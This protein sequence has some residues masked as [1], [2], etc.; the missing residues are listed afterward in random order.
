MSRTGHLQSSFGGETNGDND[1]TLLA[2]LGYKQELKR[3][4]TIVE[5]FGFGFSVNAVVPSIAATLFYSMPNG[6]P[7]AMIWGWATSS[8]F[9][10]FIALAMAELGS[11]APTS[12][13]IYYWTYK[14]CSP[15][16]R[17]LMCWM[18]GYTNTIS[19]IAG[20]AGL[21]WTCATVI[22]A[23]ASIGSDGRFVP[24]QHQTLQVSPCPCFLAHMFS[25]SGVFCAVLISQASIA[26]CAT[27]VIARLQNALIVL[28]I[29]LVLI[30]IIGL[31]IA[32]PAEF[33][34]TAKYA[35]GAFENATPWPN[36]FTF[37]LGFLAPLW[38]IS[39]FDVGVH[40]S[41]E[42]KNANVAVPWAIVIGTLAGCILGFPVQIALAFYMGTDIDAILSSPVQQPLG[43]IILN[44]F[45][46]KGM[47]VVW[48]FLLVALYGAATS[49]LTSSS[50]QTFAFSRDG[51]LVFSKILYKINSFTGTPVRCVWFSATIA[52]A[53]T[54]LTFAGPAATGAIFSLG[55]IGQYIGN[56]V[57]IAARYLGGQQFEKG[58]FYLGRFSKPV[59]GIALLWM[60]FMTL[61]L[62]FPTAPNPNA[63]DW[64][65]T[66]VVLAGVFSIALGYYYFPVFGGRHWFGGPVST[67]ETENEEK[68]SS[69]DKLDDVPN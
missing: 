42:A 51:A 2:R 58:P 26:S 44:S 47:L 65:Y 60:S 39:G 27:R 63:P 11:A 48:S 55:V 9:I 45:G 49:L 5:L 16:Y 59:A 24:T 21:N 4:F 25:H 67:V 62:L 35:F 31:P 52:A 41:E 15:R 1:K 37:I 33:K 66:V 46:K 68:L 34:N 7:T 36:G 13:G 30:I 57:P 38:A 53:L 3:E 23:G 56:S 69:S 20:V 54:L 32:T 40:I 43:T 12:G 29:A 8:V 10:M 17:N 50:R 19:Y 14:F 64:N 18:V 6:G 22:M 28:N 61:V